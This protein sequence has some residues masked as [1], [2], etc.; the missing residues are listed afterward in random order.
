MVIAVSSLMVAQ[1]AAGNYKLSGL[2]VT[3]YDVARY[4][5]PIVVDDIYGVGVSLAI[6]AIEQGEI[7]LQRL[8]VLTVKHILHMLV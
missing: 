3:Y 6:S 5:T 1:D 4:T 8:M 7:F 2:N